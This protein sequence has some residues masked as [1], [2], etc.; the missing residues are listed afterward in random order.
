[1]VPVQYVKYPKMCYCQAIVECAEGCYVLSACD[2][3]DAAGMAAPPSSHCE[4]PVC[5]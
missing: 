4:L 3:S 1:M 5:H 2:I